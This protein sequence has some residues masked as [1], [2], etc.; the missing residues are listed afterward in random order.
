MEWRR[1]GSREEND[2]IDAPSACR[3]WVTGFS[4]RI[5]AAN[6]AERVGN[7]WIEGFKGAGNGGGA[8]GRPFPVGGEAGTST[9]GGW[10]GVGM[11]LDVG[12]GA[13]PGAGPVG[14]EKGEEDFSR[15]GNG[16]FVGV[17][18][19]G[20][21]EAEKESVGLRDGFDG[22][23]VGGG[24]E[25]VLKGLGK[26]GEGKAALFAP[27]AGEFVGEAPLFGGGQVALPGAEGVFFVK[28]FAPELFEL[29]VKGAAF[30][31]EKNGFGGEGGTFV[32]GEGGVDGKDGGEEKEANGGGKEWVGTPDGSGRRGTHRRARKRAAS[33]ME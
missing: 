13:L 7:E 9:G 2:E 12:G 22:G 32:P 6:G 28:V 25:L 16:G 26:R 27:Q 5:A 11:D 8:D 31:P 3:R 19:G 23:I 21:G 17:E 1:E 24:T 30:I 15:S 10:G 20:F 29:V 14:F 18:E 4:F 33:M